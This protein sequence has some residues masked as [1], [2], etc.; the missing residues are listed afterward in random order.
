ML[1]VQIFV[2]WI[3]LRGNGVVCIEK[4]IGA[5]RILV[6]LSEEENPVLR[7]DQG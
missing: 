1:F 4:V 5:L 7:R 6:L 2:M 3:I